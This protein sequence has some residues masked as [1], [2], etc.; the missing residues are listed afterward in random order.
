MLGEYKNL[1]LLV[2]VLHDPML[3]GN[4]LGGRDTK[5]H[6]FRVCSREAIKKLVVSV[7]K[8]PRAPMLTP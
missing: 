1:L 6:Q 4:K 2:Q 5:F 3:R 8:T 7:R